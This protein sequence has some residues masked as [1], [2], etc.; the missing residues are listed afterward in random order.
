[1]KHS[2]I[3]IFRCN[4]TVNRHIFRDS[5]KHFCYTLIQW[6]QGSPLSTVSGYGLDDWAIV[7]RFL[8]EAKRIFPLI[9]VF[10]TALEPIKPP[11]QWAPGVL[12]P[13]VKHGWGVTLTAHPH[14]VPRSRISRSYT[15]LLLSAS[16]CVL[17]D[18]FTFTLI[19]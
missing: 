16:I 13:E 12:S 10:R 17:W 4:T 15:S 7:V 19:Q 9:S 5:I 14:L 11:V 3:Y 8:A 1:M 18:C 2:L 6:S